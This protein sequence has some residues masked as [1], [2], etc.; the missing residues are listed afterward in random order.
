L[1]NSDLNAQLQEKVFAITTLKY[2]LRKHKGKNVVNNAISKPNA[3]L[4]PGMFKLDIEPI[5]AA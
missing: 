5:S 2:E 4:A 1:E 3:T